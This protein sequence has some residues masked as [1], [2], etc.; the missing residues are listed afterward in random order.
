MH[1]PGRRKL[2]NG[3]FTILLWTFAAVAQ[4]SEGSPNQS[5]TAETHHAY[6]RHSGG[7]FIGMAKEGH[8][9]EGLALGIEYEYR[10]NQRFGL[11]ALAEHTF[12]DFN[13][14]VFAFPAAVHLKQWKFY[15]G[16]GIEH[17][18]GDEEPLLRIGLEYGFEY[19]DWELSPQFD[20][21]F[22]DGEETYIIGVTFIHEL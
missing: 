21:D 12:G 14:W 11:G 4:G 9:D 22:V 6:H 15:A 3:Y 7:V 17:R 13:S 18:E 19:R 2:S 16:P 1:S 10:F 20:V 8:R 5:S